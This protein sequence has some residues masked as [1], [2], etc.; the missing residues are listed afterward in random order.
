M[1]MSI[2]GTELTGD[3]LSRNYSG[4]TDVQAA[5]DL[6]TVYRTRNR[7]SMTGS[8]VLNAIVRSEYLA[9]SDA[10]K[11][12]VWQLLHLGTLDPFGVEADLISEIFTAGS[13]T[14]TALLARRKDD[15]SRAVELGLGTIAPGDIENARY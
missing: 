1:D 10:N 3:P 6:N 15:V 7:S 4:M 2:L 9:L 11:D 13:A 12:R 8:E 5:A 14:V